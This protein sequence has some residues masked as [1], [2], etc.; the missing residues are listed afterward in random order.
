MFQFFFLNYETYKYPSEF[1]RDCPQGVN[2]GSDGA[3]KKSDDPFTMT[4]TFC[5][6]SSVSKVQF[7]SHAD[8]QSYWVYSND[9]GHSN[10]CN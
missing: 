2:G 5:P 10:S 4:G 7:H 6:S 8:R 9:G 1:S 3:Y